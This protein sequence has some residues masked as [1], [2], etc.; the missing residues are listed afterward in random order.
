MTFTGEDSPLA[1]L[2]LSVL[3]AFAKFER[4]LVRERQCEG[5]YRF[6]PI[7]S[8]STSKIAPKVI[9]GL[10]LVTEVVERSL[11]LVLVRT[12]YSI[13]EQRTGCKRPD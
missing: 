6:P 2:M 11:D 1:N 10:R 8:K 7:H 12:K 3:G 9:L 5:L 13:N 4:T